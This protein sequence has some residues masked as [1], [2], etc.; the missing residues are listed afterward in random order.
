VINIPGRKAAV[1][2]LLVVG[3]V[4]FAQL[5][6]S[7]PVRKKIL[8]SLDVQETDALTT[9]RISLT[10]RVRYDSHFPYESGKELRIRITPFGI[11][12]DDLNALYKRETLVPFDQEDL[13]LEEVVYEGDIEGGPYIT[14]FFSRCVDFWVEQ[15]RDSRSI[16]VYLDEVAPEVQQQLAVDPVSE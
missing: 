11:S 10:T 1:G 15:G 2:I 9:V 13:P 6:V 5:V 16:V 12:A 14:L 3:V 8:D 4:L 7:E